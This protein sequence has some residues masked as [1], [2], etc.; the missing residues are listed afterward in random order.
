MEFKQLSAA[1]RR[2]LEITETTTVSRFQKERSHAERLN[3]N[4]QNLQTAIRS[5]RS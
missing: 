5:R 3:K 1:R 2:D 4:F